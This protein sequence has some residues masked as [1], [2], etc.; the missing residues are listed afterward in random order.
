MLCLSQNLVVAVSAE[1]W[2]HL[3]D[4]TPAKALDASGHHESLTGEEQHPVFKQHIPANTKVMLISDIGGHGCLCRRPGNRS[5]RVVEQISRDS[6]KEVAFM[7]A[8]YY[9]FYVELLSSHYQLA[10]I[11]GSD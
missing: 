4:L 11:L 9:A 5:H 10:I 1:G 2:F 7:C 6:G 8:I 3:C